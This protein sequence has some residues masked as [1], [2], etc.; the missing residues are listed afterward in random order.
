MFS[1]RLPSEA[2]EY[3]YPVAGLL[4]VPGRWL[5]G[6]LY[7]I[8]TVGYIRDG[9]IWKWHLHS[10]WICIRIIAN[11]HWIELKM[12]ENL[13]CWCKRE[14][15]EAIPK[16]NSHSRNWP[17]GGR[18]SPQRYTWTRYAGHF[19]Q[20]LLTKS[21]EASSRSFICCILYKTLLNSSR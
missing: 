6:T 11:F 8:K 3:W 13:S 10:H 18:N 17:E 7:N 14:W 16:R 2:C 15:S 20:F 5:W 9:V 19:S 4:T 21:A 1:R 12:W